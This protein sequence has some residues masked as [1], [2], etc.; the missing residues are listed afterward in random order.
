MKLFIFVGILQGLKI[1]ISKVQD[2]GNFELSPMHLATNSKVHNLDSK[3]F[4]HT[5]ILGFMSGISYKGLPNIQIFLQG[6]KIS[7]SS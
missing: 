1:W 3:S 4:T 2:F 7:S 6:V 5:L